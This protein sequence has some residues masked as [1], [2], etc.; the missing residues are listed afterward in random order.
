MQSRWRHER[1]L[2]SCAD[3]S[4]CSL[5]LLSPRQFPY[6]RL[7]T[8]G[9]VLHEKQKIRCRYDSLP[10]ILVFAFSYDAPR[11]AYCGKR[12]PARPERLTSLISCKL[13]YECPS[14]GP[15]IDLFIGDFF[16]V[17]T[18]R[19]PASEKVLPFPPIEFFH[20]VRTLVQTGVNAHQRAGALRMNS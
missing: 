5:C 16:R 18:S 15:R 11:F 20:R 4:L 19:L 10:L 12:R 1:S 3:G 13:A 14:R 6:D 8:S 2:S 9:P 7:V 17:R